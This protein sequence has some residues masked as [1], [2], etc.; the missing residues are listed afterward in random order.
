MTAVDFERQC[1]TL[2]LSGL[3]RHKDRKVMAE[4]EREKKN[5]G[6]LIV[7]TGN[8]KGKTTAA[9][10]MCV[11]AVGYD[12]Q[13]CVIQFVKGSWKYGEL[14][15]IKRLAP[16]VELHTVGEGF[17]GIVDDT[18][19]FE[20]HRA[21]ARKGVALALEKIRSRAYPLVILDEL[22]VAVDLGL[23]T[24]DEVRELLAARDAEQSL[25]VTGR[26]ARDWLVEQ[27]DL[28]TEMREIKHPFQKGVLA[29]KGIDW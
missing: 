10:G 2:R 1:S 5:T 29:Q 28:V 18:K 14:K 26:G 19:D 25:V 11:R 13:V 3:H 7:Y 22:N 27:A 15:G 6:L 17:V 9:L 21:A 20:E 4:T 24:D 8:G 23:V 16:N 12:W